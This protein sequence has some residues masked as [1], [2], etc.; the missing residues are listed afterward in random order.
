VARERPF[1][2]VANADLKQRAA[3]LAAEVEHAPK[4]RLDTLLREIAAVRDEMI[5]R[6]RG[7]HGDDGPSG[8]REPRRPLPG[9]SAAA[10][11]ADPDEPLAESPP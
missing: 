1:V 3:R 5:D 7:D 8:V 6:L 11:A 10:A 2:H 4:D 9:G